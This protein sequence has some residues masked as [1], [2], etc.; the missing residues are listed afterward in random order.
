MSCVV[1]RREEDGLYAIVEI[2]IDFDV[3]LDPEPDVDSLGR[4]LAGAER[5]CFVGNSLAVK[6][7]YTW[8]VNGRPAV[9]A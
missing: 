7:R 6:P 5:D 3:D 2:A 8:R 4:L 9:P 1:T